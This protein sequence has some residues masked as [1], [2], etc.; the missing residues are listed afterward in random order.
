MNRTL[1]QS[2]YK[3]KKIRMQLQTTGKLSWNQNIC[4]GKYQVPSQKKHHPC[5]SNINLLNTLAP[6]PR[7]R[8]ANYDNVCEVKM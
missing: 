2:V 7:G 8:G 4:T 3:I 1:Y 5:S 6:S